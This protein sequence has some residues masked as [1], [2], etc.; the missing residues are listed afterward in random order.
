MGIATLYLLCGGLFTAPEDKGDPYAQDGFLSN[1][2]LNAS[3]QGIEAVKRI[4]PRL[5]EWINQLPEDQNTWKNVSDFTVKAQALFQTYL[6]QIVKLVGGRSVRP[7]IKGG[8]ETRVTY[9]P[10]E[11]QEEALNYLESAI[12]GQFPEW[13]R[14]KELDQSG[15]FDTDQM[16]VG[17][18]EALLKHFMNKEVMESLVAGERRLGEKAFTARELFAYL[19]RVVFENFDPNKAVSTY[20]QGVQAC[21]VS[22]FARFMAQNNISFGLSNGGNGVYHAYFVELA[23]KV[24]DLSEQHQ[25]PLTRSNY[26]MMLLRMNREYF[27]KQ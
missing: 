5:S 22:E 8:N 18:A 4:Y 26:Q 2:I 19:D 24:K 6:T 25:D 23:R 7:I 11:Q 12:F 27:D 9:V 13:V 17:L 20:K 21:F 15:V 3:I 14:V 10:R 16:M 1:D